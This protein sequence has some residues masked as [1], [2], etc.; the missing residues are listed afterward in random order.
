MVNGGLIAPL[1]VK[2]GIRQGCAMS[3]MFNSVSI[4]P[5][6]CEIRKRLYYKE[7]YKV[8]FLYLF[9]FLHM[10]MVLL[11]QMSLF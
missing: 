6:L 11:S 1:N 8:K 4:E 10:Q 7:I 9:S 3:S 5:L 2:T